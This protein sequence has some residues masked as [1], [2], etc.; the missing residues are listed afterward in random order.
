VLKKI[1]LLFS[2]A[3]LVLV[4]FDSSLNDATNSLVFA[5]DHDDGVVDKI[6]GDAFTVKISFSNIGETEGEWSVN[7]AFEGNSWSQVGTS[8]NLTLQPEETEMLIWNG[9]VPVNATLDS[10]ARLVVYYDD[11]FEVLDWWIHVISG[12]ELI[13]ESSVVE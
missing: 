11:S 13:I 12:P 5:C 7:I 10:M 3:V 6:P 1:A 8:Q 9:V 2:V 4:I